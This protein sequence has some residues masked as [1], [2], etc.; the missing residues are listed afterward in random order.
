M[1]DLCVSLIIVFVAMLRYRCAEFSE[2]LNPKGRRMAAHFRLM[3]VR[4]RME[5]AIH[6]F[7][8]CAAW[9]IENQAL[10][11]QARTC[12]E[13]LRHRGDRVMIRWANCSGLFRAALPMAHPLTLGLPIAVEVEVCW[14]TASVNIDG[15]RGS[16]FIPISMR[17]AEWAVAWDRSDRPLA[18]TGRL[19]DVPQSPTTSAAVGTEDSIDQPCGRGPLA[20]ATPE[21]A[22]HSG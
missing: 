2:R 6:D 1:Y 3:F 22:N 21:T 19:I 12:L 18:P 17:P 15:R 4:P 9:S 8:T 11:L 14:R 10:N 16:H 13:S 7:G 5:F 20:G